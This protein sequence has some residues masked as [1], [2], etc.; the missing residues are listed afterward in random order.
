VPPG[1]YNPDVPPQLDAVVLHALEKNPADRFGGAEEF[2]AAL[3]GVRAGL[4]VPAGQS[5]AAFGAMAPP[6]APTAPTEAA[7]GAPPPPMTDE[8]LAAAAFPREPLPPEPE[9]ERHWLQWAIVAAIVALLVGGVLLLLALRPEKLP[10][11]NVV[12]TQLDAASTVLRN[13]GFDV[14]VQRVVNP[15]PRDRVLRQDPQP[16]TEVSEGSTVNL[17]VSDG[18][19]QVLVPDV[20]RLSK[21]RARRDLEQAGFA[22][23]LDE[24]PSESIKAGDVVRTAPPGGT[25]ADRGSSVTLYVSSGPGQVTVPDVTG[26]SQGSAQVELAG[27]GLKVDIT[28]R[29]SD[30]EPGSVISQSPAGG[31]SVDRGSTVTIVVAR[32]PRRVRVPSVVG[33]DQRAATDALSDAGLSVQVVDVAVSSEDENGVVQSQDPPAGSRVERGS[34]VTISVGRFTAS[35]PPGGDRP[36][37]E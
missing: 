6:Y 24:E 13:K 1:A 32:E 33:D 36:E 4:V 26:Q 17:T 23:E 22:V 9:R 15:A 2:I 16:R 34:R 27:A 10:V 37:G 19:G 25:L 28:E 5:T 21:D 7:A 35:P 3:E 20:S 30:A 18:P 31:A 29:D 14:D 11:P 8:E 12:G